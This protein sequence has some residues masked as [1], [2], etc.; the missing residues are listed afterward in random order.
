[1]NIA[2]LFIMRNGMTEKKYAGLYKLKEKPH[3][4]PEKVAIQS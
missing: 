1:M 2:F 3:L 4:I